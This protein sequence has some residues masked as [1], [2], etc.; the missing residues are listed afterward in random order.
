MLVGACGAFAQTTPTTPSATGVQPNGLPMTNRT[1]Q[2]IQRDVNQQ[3]RVENGLKNGSLT[4]REA[5]QIERGESNIERSEA[6]DLRKGPLTAREQRQ[7]NRAENR[8]SAVINRDEASGRVGNP[9]SASSQRMQADVQRDANQQQRVEN[10]L[11]DGSLNNSQAG[12]LERGQARDDRAQWRA[13]RDGN[14]GAGEQRHLQRMEDH[15]S[16]RIHNMRHGG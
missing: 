11:R 15:Q 8:E 7:I 9:N 2:V 1:E 6:R 3:N 12:A 14:L 13:G 5:A 4:T 16:G 10:G